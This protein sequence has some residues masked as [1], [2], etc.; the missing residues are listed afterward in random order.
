MSFKKLIHTI[1]FMQNDFQIC[2]FKHTLYIK[3]IKLKDTL[4]CLYVNNLVFINNNFN[5]VA[6]YDKTF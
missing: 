2:P 3:F 4:V 6:K 5:M 1:Y